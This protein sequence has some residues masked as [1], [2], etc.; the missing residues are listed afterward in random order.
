MKLQLNF[1][2]PIWISRETTHD[3]VVIDFRK[4]LNILKSKQKIP[5]LFRSRARAL[6]SLSEYEQRVASY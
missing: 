2:N 1:T 6:Q 3:N 4:T 5:A